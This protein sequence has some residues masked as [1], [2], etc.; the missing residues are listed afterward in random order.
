MNYAIYIC[1]FIPLKIYYLNNIIISVSFSIEDDDIL[2]SCPTEITEKA[3]KQFQEYFSGIR[4]SFDLPIQMNGTIFQKKVWNELL[5]IPY[6]QTRSYKQIAQ[7]IGNPKAVRAVG[8]ANNKNPLPIIIP[9]HRVIGSSGKLVG[10]AGGLNIKKKLL[11]LENR[12]SR[13][14]SALF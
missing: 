4:K 8:M 3:Y 6:G 5:K 10:Y 11:D 12:Y 7:N 14:K 9:C 2:K 1:D 13:E